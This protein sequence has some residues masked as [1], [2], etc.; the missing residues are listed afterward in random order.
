MGRPFRQQIRFDAAQQMK[1]V[2]LSEL[3]GGACR[4]QV[5]P[6]VDV[7]SA[8]ATHSVLYGDVG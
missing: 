7:L 3:S 6:P 5:K 2:L 8:D 4:R 1:H